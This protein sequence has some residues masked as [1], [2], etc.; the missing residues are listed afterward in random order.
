MSVGIRKSPA[1]AYYQDLLILETMRF[2]NRRTGITENNS[3]I[4][5]FGSAKEQGRKLPFGE[6]AGKA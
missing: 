5:K 2:G 1:H 6:A 4:I 3:K